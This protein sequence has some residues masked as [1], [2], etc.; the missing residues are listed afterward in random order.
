LKFNQDYIDPTYHTINHMEN[1]GNLD[2]A[3]YFG[4][5]NK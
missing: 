2:T 4:I 1:L 5:W 3:C